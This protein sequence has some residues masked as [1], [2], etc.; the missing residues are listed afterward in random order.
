MDRF[1]QHV[2]GRQKTDVG[3]FAH[4][5]RLADAEGLRNVLVNQRLALF[6]E[7]D[8]G[9]PVLLQHGPHGSPHLER[10]ARTDHHQVGDGTQERDVL[11][12][13]V[14][15]AETRVGQTRTDRHDRDRRLVVAGVGADLLQA[16][17]RDERRDGV[18]ERAESRHRQAGGDAHHVLLGDTAVEKA[19]RGGRSELVEQAIA[20]IAREHDDPG[21]AAELGQLVS[22]RIPHDRPS[23][24]NAWATS[25]AEGAR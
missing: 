19:L 22:E 10:V 11:A 7:A 8:I 16:A 17:G 1:G 25:A 13:M 6:P 20:D 18:G 12:G 14:R 15:R 21:I 2:A 9:R 4:R 23:S 3:P 5:Q 24:A